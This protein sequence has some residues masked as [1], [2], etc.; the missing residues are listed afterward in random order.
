MS[1]TDD[2]ASIASSSGVSLVVSIPKC[3]SIQRQQ[4]INEAFKHISSTAGKI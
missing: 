2:S 4:N 3:S 1:A